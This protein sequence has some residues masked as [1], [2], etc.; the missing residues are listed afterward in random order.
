M[1]LLR[2]HYRLPPQ[3]PAPLPPSVASTSAEVTAPSLPTAITP[4]P[5]E[6]PAEVGGVAPG[7]KLPSPPLTSPNL[8]QVLEQNSTSQ[9]LH[10]LLKLI[11]VSI[12][13]D[14]L[15]ADMY[16]IIYATIGE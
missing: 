12:E 6:C 2:T 11:E 15:K 3:N 9:D 13:A 4:A 16:I 8:E 10:E 14:V 1:I 7:F 5:L